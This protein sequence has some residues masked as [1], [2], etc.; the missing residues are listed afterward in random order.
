M[1]KKK[2][3]QIK[4]SDIESIELTVHVATGNLIWKKFDNWDDL[5]EF[6]N[7]TL[8]DPEKICEI[9]SPKRNKQVS[10][11]VGFYDTDVDDDDGDW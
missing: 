9:I 7:A 4:K 3:P 10:E 5:A 1:N 11:Q 6:A 8:R 2:K